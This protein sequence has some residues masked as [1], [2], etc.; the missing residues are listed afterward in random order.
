MSLMPIARNAA[1]ARNEAGL[2]GGRLWRFPTLP[3]TNTWALEHIDQLGHGD[4]VWAE[5]QTAGRGRLDRVWLAPPGSSLTLSV[6]VEDAALTPLAANL[7]QLAA[8]AVLDSLTEN[9]IHAELKWPN[10][11]MAHECKLAGLLVEQASRSGVYILGVGLNVNATAA[12][13]TAAG[14]D[15]PVTSM[16]D[17]AGRA[18]DPAEILVALLRNLTVRMDDVR[19]N[20]LVNIWETWKRHDWLSGR[21]VCVTNQGQTLQ[22][23]YLGLDNEG[24]LRI[25]TS[26][27]AEESLW[28]GDVSIQ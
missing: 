27:G 3:S 18:F 13:L 23:T 8:C 17:L 14:L 25:R 15:R 4:V 5:A 16:R 2:W 28:T 1:M 21:H 12:E 26:A 7:G 11:V 10:D 20:A 6:V 9:S 22:G 19:T 24:R